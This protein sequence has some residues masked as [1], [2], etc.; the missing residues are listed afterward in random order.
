MPAGDSN[1]LKKGNQTHGHAA[2]VKDNYESGTFTSGTLRIKASSHS[3]AFLF[4]SESVGR[5]LVCRHLPLRTEHGFPSAV[6]F[7]IAIA[8]AALWHADKDAV[9]YRK[10]ASMLL[11]AAPGLRDIRLI[12]TDSDQHIL[13]QIHLTDNLIHQIKKC[14]IRE[15]QSVILEAVFGRRIGCDSKWTR[16]L[17]DFSGDALGRLVECWKS[18]GAGGENFAQYFVKLK[19]PLLEIHY[20]DKSKLAREAAVK[21][22][23]TQPYQHLPSEQE[24]EE[25]NKICRLKRDPQGAIL[26]EIEGLSQEIVADYYDTATDE[27]LAATDPDGIPNDIEKATFSAGKVF[28]LMNINNWRIGVHLQVN[29]NASTGR[30]SCDKKSFFRRQWH[31]PRDKST[32]RQEEREK[33]CLQLRFQPIHAT[34]DTFV[35]AARLLPDTTFSS[36]RRVGLSFQKS[37]VQPCTAALDPSFRPTPSGKMPAGDSNEVKNGGQTNGHAAAAGDDYESGTFTSGSLRVKAPS[38][39][40]AFLFTSESVGAGHPDKMCDQISDAVL[41]AHI[42]QDPNAKV[43][44]ESVT[45]TGMVLVC[46]EITSNAVVDYQKVIRDTVREIGYDSSEKGFDGT[47]CNILIALEQQA[48]EIGAGVH[49]GRNELD[50]GAGD[51]GIMFGYATDETEEAMPL[52]LHLSHRMC[53]RYSDLMKNGTFPWARPDCK[54]QVTAEY[55]YDSGACV[56]QR[57]HTVV[58][59]GQ[60]SPKVTLAEFRREVLEKVIKHVIP[61]HLLDNETVYHINPCGTFIMGGP[62]NDAGLT[63]RKIIVDTYGGWGAHGGGAFSGKDPTKVDRSAAYAARWV[64]KSLVKAG[65]ARRVLVQVSYAIGIAAPLSVSIFHYG[66]S[67]YTER[68][69]L[70]I[71]QKNFDLRPGVIMREL[72]LKRPIYKETASYGHFGRKQFP[73]EVPK[74]IV[75]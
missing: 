7:V 29:T 48:P 69:L 28:N 24:V 43:A 5:P 73:W 42:A 62:F 41:D 1:M 38:H 15:H 37:K 3:D 34:L 64:A 74:K 36:P 16:C 59:S 67:K 6:H 51:Q 17:I 50:V 57:V 56:P 32:F 25:I 21:R 54:S 47:T 61:E 27:I 12:G 26:A 71:V 23:H 8:G 2:A 39:P 20:S 10:M 70:E 53:E 11:V 14:Q 46:G 49:L 65:L 66:S 4:T 68:E 55:I 13:C 75:L 40:D 35:D 63:G 52:T 45:K 22:I 33:V 44:C 18:F 19:A 9:S 30:L 60:H 58:F 31:M 72:S